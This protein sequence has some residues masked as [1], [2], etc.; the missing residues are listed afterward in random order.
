MGVVGEFEDDPI[1]GVLDAAQNRCF[2]VGGFHRRGHYGFALVHVHRGM[3]TASAAYEKRA[4]TGV[5]A[6][7]DHVADVGLQGV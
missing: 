7:F 6:V 3:F 5:D 4:L 2:T 1:V